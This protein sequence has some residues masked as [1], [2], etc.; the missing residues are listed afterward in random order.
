[1]T[2]AKMHMKP[3]ADC[4]SV[5]GYFLQTK[6]VQLSLKKYIAKKVYILKADF[7]INGGGRYDTE[8]NS[9]NSGQKCPR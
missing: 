5:T 1:M 3:W 6:T 2:L 9:S 7:M 4:S 8:K